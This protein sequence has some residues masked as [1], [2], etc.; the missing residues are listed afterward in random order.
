MEIFQGNALAGAALPAW[1]AWA[2]ACE[3]TWIWF[4]ATMHMT[5]TGE[6]S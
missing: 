4:P 3:L 1:L 2:I 5:C 6:T